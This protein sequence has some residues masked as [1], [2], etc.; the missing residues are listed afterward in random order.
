M[1]DQSLYSGSAL[2][3]ALV[4]GIVSGAWILLSDRLV[5]AL[6]DGESLTATVQTAKGWLFVVASSA[7]LFALVHRSQRSRK[8]T[9]ER[10]DR[11]LQQTS[12]LHRILRHNL[13][14]SC[15]VIA[16][17]AELIAA[18]VEEGDG[19][20]EAD[21]EEGADDEE[22]STATG[23]GQRA[24][25]ECLD[26][27]RSQTE[28]LATI[29]E[30][31]RLLRDLVLDEQPDQTVDLAAVVADRV[32]AARE[33]YPE[34][35]FDVAAPPAL[36]IETDPRIETAVDELLENA[37]EHNDRDRPSVAVALE[38]RADGVVHLEVS[39]DG[40]GMPEMER[41]VLEEGMEGPMFHSEGLGLWIAR[42]VV[43]NVGGEIQIVDN[44]PRGTKVRVSIP[45]N[46]P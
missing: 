44:E 29:T 26:T 12:V 23:Q 33:R 34:A 25:E 22:V 36:Q 43:D 10:L 14:N 19:E 24:S 18:H 37:V 2:D 42:T 38:R 3:I 11:A 4:Y 31:T 27:I 30:K 7:L 39:D 17:N 35:S 15:N 32:E 28:R 1:S 41:A 20:G 13:R 5:A 45:G 16:G 21:D 8:R 9:N 6:V 40:P 46:R